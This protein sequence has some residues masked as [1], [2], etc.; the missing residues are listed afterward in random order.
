[1]EGPLADRNI[2]RLFKFYHIGNISY[3]KAA[4]KDKEHIFELIHNRVHRWVG[5]EMRII[6]SAADDPFFFIY[7][8]FIS[9]IWEDFRAQQRSKGID[10][11]TDWDVFY[12]ATRH[13]K[14]AP[15]GL[16]NLMAID[17]SSEVFAKNII[18]A[19]RP[20]CS[21]MN[22]DCGSPYLYCNVTA[23]KCATWTLHEYNTIKQNAV[24]KNNQFEVEVMKYIDR[25]QSGIVDILF[26]DE[27]E[28][29]N[30]RSAGQDH[31][32]NDGH[33]S[34]ISNEYNSEVGEPSDD[35]HD[36]DDD[37]HEDDGH[38]H[39]NQATVKNIFKE[40]NVYGGRH[41]GTFIEKY[42]LMILLAGTLFVLV[43]LTVI[44]KCREE[45]KIGGIRKRKYRMDGIVNVNYSGSERQ[46]HDSTDKQQNESRSDNIYSITIISHTGTPQTFVRFAK[47]DKEQNKQ[48]GIS[49]VSR[50][51]GSKNGDYLDMDYAS[52]IMN[53]AKSCESDLYEI[54]LETD[55]EGEENNDFELETTYNSIENENFDLNCL[56]DQ[57][58]PCDQQCY[59]NATKSIDDVLADYDNLVFRTEAIYHNASVNQS[60]DSMDL[61]FDD[62]EHT[63]TDSD[64]PS[65]ACNYDKIVTE[66][67]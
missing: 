19:K 34:N 21:K 40:I 1:M 50:N 28:N 30:T 65:L 12:G 62:D 53:E 13:H 14:Y 10:P 39:H 41:D 15:M 54:S 58:E 67:I 35:D 36:D 17:G 6:Q 18:F 3:P 33:G 57:N 63:T 59:D 44:S 51:A 42:L 24:S 7:H 31:T 27:S 32:D 48:A 61:K 29:H 38:H 64:V 46:K 2:S 26:D 20:S 56:H 66:L 8:S 11:E 4:L 25:K 37:D 55:S 23:E 22:T 47:Y 60:H 49:D 16:G 45:H 5:G 9:L 52:R 43:I